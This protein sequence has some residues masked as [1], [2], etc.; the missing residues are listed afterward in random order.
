MSAERI[1]Q[2]LAEYLEHLGRS[3]IYP[4]CY[5]SGVVLFV[6]TAIPAGLYMDVN[7]DGIGHALFEPARVNGLEWAVYVDYYGISRFMSPF[8]YVTSYC[9]IWFGLGLLW[10]D[11]SV[12]VFLKSKSRDL[13]PPKELFNR[14]AGRIL[15]ELRA[16]RIK[17]GPGSTCLRTCIA[18][19]PER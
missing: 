1:L 12:F 5:W 18:L 19:P 14:Y 4:F 8:W 17:P 7:P 15:A 6:A 11:Y 9:A 2:E 10:R 3:R 16:G 13:G